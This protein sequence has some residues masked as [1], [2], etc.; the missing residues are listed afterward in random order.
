MP[1]TPAGANA[2]ALERESVMIQYPCLLSYLCDFPTRTIEVCHPSGKLAFKI[3]AADLKALV[4]Y[5][6]VTPL[7][8]KYGFLKAVR[9]LVSVVAAL[10][11]MKHANLPPMPPGMIT[12]PH[13]AKGKPTWPPRY[14]R[15]RC[16]H[17]GGVV[18]HIWA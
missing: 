18:M 5:E 16:G 8:N 3:E 14:D 13:Y 12:K 15:A 4:R 10:R 11:T 1:S 9:L 2:G 6:M 7:W 17:M